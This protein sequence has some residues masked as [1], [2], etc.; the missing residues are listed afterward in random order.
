MRKFL[1]CLLLLLPSLLAFAQSTPKVLSG[2]D[3]LLSKVDTIK[4]PRTVPIVEIPAVP[5]SDSLNLHLKSADSLNTIVQRNQNN[6]STLA[7]APTE[8]SSKQNQ[9]I[10]TMQSRLTH[11]IDSLV[12]LPT[13]DPSKIKSLDSLRGRLDSLKNIRVASGAR[14]R[15][16][17]LLRKV[18]PP[19]SICC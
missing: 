17:G 5:L 6:V 4:L 15:S 8:W 2:V 3:S 10:S 12:R 7:S 14:L 19:R 18:M 11:R 9:R 16:C 13:P 1:L